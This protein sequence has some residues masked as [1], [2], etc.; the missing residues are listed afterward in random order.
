[1]TIATASLKMLSPKMMA[2]RLTSAFISLKIARTDT[3]S[4]ALIKLPKANDSFQL[5]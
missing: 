5:N 4:V 1:M 2:N 3:G